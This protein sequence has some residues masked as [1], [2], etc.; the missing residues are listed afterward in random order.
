MDD[1]DYKR[2]GDCEISN[3]AMIMLGSIIGKK[4]RRYLNGEFE[5]DSK[6]V[7]EENVFI[8][9]QCLVGNGSVIGKNSVLDDKSVI[10]SHVEIGEGNLV[11]YGAQICSEVKIGNECVIGGFIGE[12]TII[13]NN[14][15]IFGSIVHSQYEPL[16]EWDAEDSIEDAPVIH[17]EVFIGFNS[18]ISA[19]VTIGPR[20]YVCAG[21][22]VTLN[23]PERHIASGTNKIIHY[24]EWE[25]T[26]KDSNFFK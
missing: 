10:E 16:N 26:L 8:G 21:S 2:I 5:E 1:K 12:R 13:G 22:I 18:I 20:A 3:S 17:D 4:Y 9:Y 14:C 19:S 11:I 7:V 15:R 24:S 23:V 25:G 6:T